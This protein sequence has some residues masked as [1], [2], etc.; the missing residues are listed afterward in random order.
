MI[1]LKKVRRKLKDN[2]W[3]MC[4]YGAYVQLRRKNEQLHFRALEAEER[5]VR[6]Q[7]ALDDGNEGL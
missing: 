6:M 7:R 5:L 1:D 2:K 4:L 3:G